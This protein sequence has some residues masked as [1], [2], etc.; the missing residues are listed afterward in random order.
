QPVDREAS[1]AAVAEA[2]AELVSLGSPEEPSDDPAST[3]P[4]GGT[5]EN[6]ESTGL[7]D[8]PSTPPGHRQNAAGDGNAGPEATPGAVTKADELGV[9]LA[10]VTGTGEGGR[11]LAKDIE[12]H[13]RELRRRASL[14]AE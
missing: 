11:I 9:D 5:P 13:A 1:E 14:D 3:D 6:P 2:T 10:D 4:D 12:R 8:R 7:T